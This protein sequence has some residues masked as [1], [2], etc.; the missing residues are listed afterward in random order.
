MDPF[1]KCGEN[2]I[3]FG[4][5]F[6]R[7]HPRTP[8]NIRSGV[9]ELGWESVGVPNAEARCNSSSAVLCTLNL[10]TSGDL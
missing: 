5:A 6:T 2:L 9:N 10:L 7:D 3:K 8:K 1:I 4:P